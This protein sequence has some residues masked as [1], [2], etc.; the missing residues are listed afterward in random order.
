MTKFEGF[1]LGLWWWPIINLLMEILSSRQMG[2]RA[3]E[4][5]LEN[6]E[7]IEW[8]DWKGRTRTIKIHREVHGG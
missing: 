6:I 4:V 8:T 3:S 5:K 2:A 7:E 1:G